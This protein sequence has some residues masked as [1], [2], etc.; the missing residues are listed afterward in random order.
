LDLEPEDESPPVLE[1][2]FLANGHPFDVSQAEL[3]DLSDSSNETLMMSEVL[4]IPDQVL[5]PGVALTLGN[6][7]MSSTG[8]QAYLAP[9]LG[10]LLDDPF[11]PDCQPSVETSS[12]P[13]QLPYDV[14]QMGYKSF[15]HLT[16]LSPTMLDSNGYRVHKTNSPFSYH[17]SL[18]EH[19]VRQQ[20]CDPA[21]VGSRERSLRYV[22]LA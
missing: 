13:R 2:I 3:G 12:I 1:S 7:A 14:S 22:Q 4:E 6:E 18:V 11:L 8:Y 10:P 15:R 21:T 17:I 20:W 19:L 5:K 9:Q 16:E